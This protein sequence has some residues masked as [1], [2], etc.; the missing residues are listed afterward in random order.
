VY[1]SGPGIS[2]TA[3]D[4][5]LEIRPNGCYTADGPPDVIGPLHI[6]KAGGGTAI[7]PLFAFDGCMVAP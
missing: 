1:A 5:T 4:Y 7:N 3:L 6:R 2:Q